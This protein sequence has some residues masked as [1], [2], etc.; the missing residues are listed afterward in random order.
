[1]I[2]AASGC[3]L[4]IHWF[5]KQGQAIVPVVHARETEVR[6]SYE[7]LSHTFSFRLSYTV[8][9]NITLD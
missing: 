9:M 4:A 8:H 7:F 5:Y 3:T 2:A 6:V 1:M